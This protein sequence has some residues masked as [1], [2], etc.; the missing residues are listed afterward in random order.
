MGF[1]TFVSS[2]AHDRRYVST[3]MRS[4][5]TFVDRTDAG[6]Q[7]ARRLEAKRGDRVVV[8]GLARG[9]VPVALEVAKGLE[10]PLD[11]LVIRKIGV[12]FQPEVAMGAIGEN[13]VRVVDREVMTSLGLSTEQFRAVERVERAELERRLRRY[14]ADRTT[15]SLEGRT[16]VIVDDGVATGSTA[17]AACQVARA[18]GA[19]RIVLAVPVAAA[20]ALSSLRADTDELVVLQSVDG[21][22]AVGQFYDEFDQTSDEEVMT[23]LAQAASRGASTGG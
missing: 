15:V 19:K 23:A 9:G 10:A 16:V 13:G 4:V 17:K 5:R 8:L 6:R 2:G 11:L 7:L 20:D 22:F 21:P 1:V 12:P 3:M 18:Q 14:R